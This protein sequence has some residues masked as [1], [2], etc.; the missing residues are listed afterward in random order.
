MARRV[1]IL[2]AAL[3]TVA[4]AAAV[5]VPSGASEHGPAPIV[6]EELTPRSV[7][8][9]TVAL[10]VRLRLAGDPTLVLNVDDPSRVVTARITVQPGAQFPWHT[11]PGPVVA[12]VAEGALTYVN[13]GDCVERPYEAG[14]VFVDPGRG[15]VHTAFNPTEAETVVMATFFEAPEAGPLSIGAAAPG[16]CDV[17]ASAHSH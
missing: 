8:T 9:D 16:D 12:V 3:A 7:L 2:A 6:V 13:A 11:H 5:A 1:S 14:S 15:N 10:Q 4:G 17:Q